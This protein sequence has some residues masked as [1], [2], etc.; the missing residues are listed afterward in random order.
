MENVLNNYVGK[1]TDKVSGIINS[2]KN[3]HEG[4]VGADEQMDM[5][6]C[7]QQAMEEWCQAEKC[8]EYVSDPDLVDYA[9][10]RIQASK[11]KYDYL[12]KKAKE[13]GIK[14]DLHQRA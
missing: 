10:Y 5:I 2:I 1:V 11:K 13:M 4:Q 12:L 9:I 6:R 7:V 3:E 8:F 14:V